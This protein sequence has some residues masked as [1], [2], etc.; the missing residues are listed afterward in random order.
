MG[1]AAAVG[2]ELGFYSGAGEAKQERKRDRDYLSGSEDDA[3]EKAAKQGM[4][5]AGAFSDFKVER[6]RTRVAVEPE[7]IEKDNYSSDVHV[8]TLDP[9]DG[10]PDAL[11]VGIASS[12]NE[13]Q[14]QPDATT[15]GSDLDSVYDS[16]RKNKA[17]ATASVEM[18]KAE[19]EDRPDPGFRVYHVDSITREET[20]IPPYTSPQAL[21]SKKN[22]EETPVESVNKAESKYEEANEEAV[23]QQP[24]SDYD[25]TTYD[26]YQTIQKANSRSSRDEELQAMKVA[27][28]ANRVKASQIDESKIGVMKM[29]DPGKS[30]KHNLSSNENLSEIYSTIKS[31]KEAAVSSEL[32]M[33]DGKVEE[34]PDPGI[35]VYHV[36]VDKVTRKETEISPKKKQ[37]GAT[38]TCSATESAWGAE[39]WGE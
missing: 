36:R 39:P 15:E 7:T 19:K 23:S 5:D 29:D 26:G 2:T 35:R 20:E 22:S 30:E 21:F 14:E 3:F 9:Y 11:T 16:I 18:T 8:D 32:T 10:S 24:S 4:T 1:V 6:P 13:L 38:R 27:R 28:M 25:E 37:S 12:S 31:N 17:K 34:W 33:Q